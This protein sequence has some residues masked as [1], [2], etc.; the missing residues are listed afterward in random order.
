MHLSVLSILKLFTTVPLGILRG[1]TDMD[2]LPPDFAEYLEGPRVPDTTRELL[3]EVLSWMC[4]THPELETRIAWNQ[5]MF[6][7][8]GTF[9]VGFSASSKHL[10]FAPEVPVLEQLRSA[11]SERGYK[12]LKKTVNLPLSLSLP[13]DLLDEAVAA[14]ME[15]K[16]DVTSF[17]LPSE[18]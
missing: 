4:T 5:P 13:F 1:M 12:C 9:I 16:K 8:H 11:F 14:Q 10:S 6:T 7:H 15:L 3:R 18:R 17:W 2:S